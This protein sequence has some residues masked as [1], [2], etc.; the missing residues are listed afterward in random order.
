MVHNKKLSTYPEIADELKKHMAAQGLIE[1]DKDRRFQNVQ[2]IAMRT[3]MKNISKLS[4][5]N[6]QDAVDAAI[7]KV[8]GDERAA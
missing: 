1:G 7:E 8:F 2:H 4:I 5:N 3:I 6:I